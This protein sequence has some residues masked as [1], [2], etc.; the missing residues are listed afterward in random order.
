MII[1]I[2]CHKIL[3]FLFFIYKYYKNK[4]KEYIINI[5]KKKTVINLEFYRI[6]QANLLESFT[7]C[8]I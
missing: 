6:R 4:F 2:C 5:I 7:L 1:N 8:F 3:I